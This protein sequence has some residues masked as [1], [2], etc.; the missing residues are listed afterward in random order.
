MVGKGVIVFH[1][2][3][4]LPILFFITQ[5]G[6]LFKVAAVLH[7]EAKNTIESTLVVRLTFKVKIQLF[8]KVHCQLLRE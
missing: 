1:K 5:K 6:F 7:S 2:H 8:L 4:F 3:P